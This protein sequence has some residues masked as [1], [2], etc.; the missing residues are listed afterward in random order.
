MLSVTTACSDSIGSVEPPILA[1]PPLGLIATCERPV[2]LPSRS[3]TQVE[4]EA[5]WIRDRSNLINCRL[6]L[7]SLIDFYKK[8]DKRITDT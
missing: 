8:R 7:Q 5:Y 3:L 6:Q 1:D 2:L 4:V